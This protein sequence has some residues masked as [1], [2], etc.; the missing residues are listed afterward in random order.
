MVFANSI[1]GINVYRLVAIALQ[2]ENTYTIP[3]LLDHRVFV[4]KFVEVGGGML[5][6][7]TYTPAMDKYLH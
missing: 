4:L 2:F 3:Y 1:I 5:V 7:C 6:C